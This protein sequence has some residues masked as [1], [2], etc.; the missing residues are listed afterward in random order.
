[1]VDAA[2]S[3]TPIHVIGRRISGVV[4]NAAAN[5][6]AQVVTLLFCVGWLAIGGLRSI[7]GLADVLAVA[8]ITLTQMVLNQQKVH[9]AALHLKLDELIHAKQGARDELVAIEKATEEELE[10]LRRE[11]AA[12]E[13]E[14]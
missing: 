14:T 10:A 7:D 4:A 12:E 9:D 11:V 1:M 3:L 2:K 6:W 5:P 8:A 13:R